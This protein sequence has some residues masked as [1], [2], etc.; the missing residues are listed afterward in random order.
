MQASWIQRL[1][2]IVYSFSDYFLHCMCPL[3]KIV[4][5]QKQDICIFLEFEV[6]ELPLKLGQ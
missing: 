4:S 2:S 5:Y 1:F 6:G 3:V